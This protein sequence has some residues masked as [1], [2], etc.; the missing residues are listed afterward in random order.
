MPE[1]LP[2]ARLAVLQDVHVGAAQPAG[3]HL[4]DDLVGGGHRVGDL[5]DLRGR[6][7]AH[8]G[9][10]LLPHRPFVAAA[11]TRL[12]RAGLRSL[13]VRAPP[14]SLMR[15]PAARKGKWPGKARIVGAD[16]PGALSLCRPTVHARLR[17]MG[18]TVTRR[19]GTAAFALMGCLATGTASAGV[20]SAAPASTGAGVASRAAAAPCGPGLDTYNRTQLCWRVA[21]TVAVVQG[22]TRVGTVTLD[23]THDIE[24]NPR[25]R[26]FAERVTISE[27][28][29]TGSAVGMTMTLL[30]SCA[31]PCSAADHFP[32]G[33]VVTNGLTGVIDYSDAV[34]AGQADSART[35]YQLS[36]VKPG[37]QPI[38]LSYQAPLGY[39]CDDALPGV[40]AG[41]V[42]PAYTPYLSTLTT[43]PDVATD[44]Y[45]AQTGP[46]HY[47][48][49]GSGHPLHRSTSAAAQAANYAAICGRPVV[50][51][52]PHGQACDEYPFRSTR[53]GGT[54]VGKADRLAAWIP[55][56]EENAKNALI[57]S[58]CAA[59]R[60]L[61]GDPYWV[62]V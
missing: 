3:V 49:P 32:Q 19:F 5:G 60:V 9:K 38:G 14:L 54:G 30:A 29:A 22:S 36:F 6:A 37:A 31:K 56:A 58:F 18:D 52:S 50:G 27:V 48:R 43:L 46:G 55:A 15:R 44:A 20:A 28:R 21:A 17:G 35:A 42:F 61:N 41:C 23:L 34:A 25:G 12:S 39:R 8:Y 51:P 10:H 47:G 57:T 45:V 11:R 24:L 40:P 33:K 1:N 2:V 7:M 13:S 59:N 53:E 4:D 26:A 16:T 62:S